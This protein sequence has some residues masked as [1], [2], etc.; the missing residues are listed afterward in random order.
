MVGSKDNILYTIG[1]SNHTTEKFLS[2]LKQYGINC[3]AD[4]R[5]APYSRYCPQFNKEAI[6]ASLEAA[7]IKYIFMGKELGGKPEDKSCYEDGKVSF[8][9]I[10]ES[11]G[12]KRGVEQL[13]ADISQ[14][15]IALMCAE[16]DPLQCHRTIL[17]SRYFKK[18]KVGIK[19]ILEDGS[20]EEHKEAERRLVK[21]LKVEPTLF[22][23]NKEETETVEQA[24]NQ[25]TEKIL[26]QPEKQIEPYEWVK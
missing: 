5:S 10:A 18:Y 12:F 17:I 9:R 3:V 23:P 4:V 7:G 6:A 19:H 20:I 1:H 2:L 26:H 21:V 14:Y 22:E 15:R 24:Y 25:Q 16:K 11:D 13:L 8:E